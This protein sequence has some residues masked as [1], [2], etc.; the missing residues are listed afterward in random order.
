MTSTGSVFPV[1]FCTVGSCDIL[2]MTFR[3]EA[4]NTDLYFHK[5][6]VLLE[7]VSFCPICFGG[8]AHFFIPDCELALGFLIVLSERLQLLHSFIL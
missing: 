5:H 7:A 8:R 4:S 3:V 6:I 1:T 2:A